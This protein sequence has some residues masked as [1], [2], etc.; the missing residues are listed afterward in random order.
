GM[1]A[2][3]RPRARHPEDR[4]GGRP[5]A[6]PDDPEGGHGHPRPGIRQPRPAPVSRSRHARRPPA[7]R[8]PPG[9]R[10]GDPLLPRGLARAARGAGR[11]RDRVPAVTRPDA[12]NVGTALEADDLPARTG[13][14]AALVV[15][16]RDH[17]A[18]GGSMVTSPQ[19]GVMSTSSTRSPVDSIVSRSPF[20]AA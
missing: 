18:T 20:P 7:R 2:L 4:D 17:E 12:R 11:P 8:A 10:V 6:R 14:V 13:S 9:V 1:P 16:E 15:V 19:W 3:R 5:V